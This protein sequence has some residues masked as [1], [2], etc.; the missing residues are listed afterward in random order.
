MKTLVTANQKGGVG[1]TSSVIHLAFDAA[2]RGKKVA[3]IDLDTQANASFTL[4]EYACGVTASELF[5]AGDPKIAA[6]DGE[7]GSITLIEADNGLAGLESEKIAVAAKYFN[8]NIKAVAE[9]GFDVCLVDTAPALG[10]RMAAALLAADYVISPIELETYSLQGIKQMVTTVSNLRRS[11]PR[12]E[13]LG[14]V[15]SKVDSRNPRHV[16]HQAELKEAYP[17]MMVPVS[18][19]LR[20]SVADAVA[21]RVPVWKIKKTA[22]RKAAKEMRALAEYVFTKMEIA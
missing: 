19:G 2:E 20:S 3:V 11:N 13:F 1:K 10:V 18:I 15:A 17:K 21:T 6:P 14:M 7:G 9:G 4:R 8:Q 5:K 22:A 12:L 16:R